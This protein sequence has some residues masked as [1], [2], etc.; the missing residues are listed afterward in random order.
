M[1]STYNIPS[2]YLAY[3][4]RG[5]DLGILTNKPNSSTNSQGEWVAIDESVTD[6]ILINYLAEPDAVTSV[7]DYPDID[8][9]LHKFV[10]DFVKAELFL[11]EAGK[12]AMRGN[13]NRALMLKNLA[14]EHKKIWTDELVKFGRKKRDKI[15][16]MR[17]MQPVDYR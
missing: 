2:D 15:G 6:G 12:A 8:N 16:G 11:E 3:I 10:A 17:V 14:T 9:T 7:T 5:D 1:A 4:I 13:E